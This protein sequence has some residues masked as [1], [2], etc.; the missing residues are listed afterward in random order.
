MRVTN[1]LMFNISPFS[2]SAACNIDSQF[3]SPG[4]IPEL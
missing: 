1:V 3:R 4:E 2:M